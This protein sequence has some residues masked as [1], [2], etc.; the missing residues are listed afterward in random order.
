MDKGDT[1]LKL[2][3]SILDVTQIEAGRRLTFEPVSVGDLVA[4]A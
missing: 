2:I 3:S 1:L 4:S